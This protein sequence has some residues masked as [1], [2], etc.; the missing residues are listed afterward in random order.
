MYTEEQH[1]NIVVFLP[2]SGKE[3]CVQFIRK[4]NH[5][6]LHEAGRGEAASLGS[7]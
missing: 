5:V 2:Y 6:L 3:R 1:N 7:S 4:V